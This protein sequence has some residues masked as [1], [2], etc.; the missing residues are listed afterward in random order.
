MSIVA[1]FFIPH[2]SWE[3]HSAMP[4]TLQSAPAFELPPPSERR[5][6]R[7]FLFL[8]LLWIVGGISLWIP[9]RHHQEILPGLACFAVG[10]IDV[11]QWWQRR[12]RPA[13]AFAP[14]DN[15]DPRMRW[16]CNIDNYSRFI[17]PSLLVPY[18]F[19]L[20]CLHDLHPLVTLFLFIPLM[21]VLEIRAI[22]KQH[23]PP[24][25]S[26]PRMLANELRSIPVSSEHWGQ[27]S[28]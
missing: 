27:R 26:P 9:I 11:H 8:G 12:Y 13:N 10:L 23:T 4:E 19:I 20:I 3:Y 25:P 14:W 6:G 15:D 17:L 21:L 2:R 16:L 7:G 18:F 5:S 1:I 28:V 24:P 22:K